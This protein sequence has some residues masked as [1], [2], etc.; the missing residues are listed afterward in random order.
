V[1]NLVVTATRAN[2]GYVGAMTVV[3]FQGA[4]STNGAVAVGNASTGAPSVSLTTTGAGSW[5]W[6]V[7]NDWDHAMGRTVGSNQTLVDQ[8]LASVGDTYWVQRQTAV[9]PSAGTVVPINDT[10]PTTDRWDLA[11]V[12]ILAS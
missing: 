2:G 3:A 11:A 7:G 8:Y 5:V 4:S 6:G 9:T 1:S 12:E 10:A